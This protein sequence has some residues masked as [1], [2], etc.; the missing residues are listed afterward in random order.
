MLTKYLDMSNFYCMFLSK[1][2]VLKIF[3]EYKDQVILF[4]DSTVI[5]P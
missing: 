3:I 4:Y 2:T 5:S 1:V